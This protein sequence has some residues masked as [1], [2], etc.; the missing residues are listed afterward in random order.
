MHLVFKI[1]CSNMYSEQEIKRMEAALTVLNGSEQSV[2]GRLVRNAL[3]G[4]EVNVRQLLNELENNLKLVGKNGDM[5]HLTSE[6]RAAAAMGMKAYL[7]ERE[8]KAS[9]PIPVHLVDNRPLW[10]LNKRELIQSSISA[11]IGAVIGKAVELLCS[12]L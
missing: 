3:R 7:A 1:N 4:G 2:E 11:I 8:Q 9:E 6:G 5:W 10:K 12:F